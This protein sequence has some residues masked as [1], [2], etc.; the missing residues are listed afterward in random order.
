MLGTFRFW[1]YRTLVSLFTLIAFREQKV[2]PLEAPPEGKVDFAPYSDVHP[3]I[4]IKGLYMPTSFLPADKPD[5]RLKRIKF[6]TKLLTLVKGLAPATTP[7]VPTNEADFIAAVYPRAFRWAWP[8]APTVP[9]AIAATDDLVAELAVRGPYASF[10]RK[11]DDDRY[12]FGADWIGS[13]EVEPGLV[14]PGGTATLVATGGRLTTESIESAGSARGQTALLAA[15]NEDL[16]TFRHNVDVHL[17]IL[18]SF[19]LACTNHLGARHPVRRLLHHCFNTVMIGNFELSSAQLRGPRS[20]LPTIFSHR[21]EVLVRMVEDHLRDFDFWDY[22]P[23]TQFSRRGTTTTPFEYPYRDNVMDFWTE[24]SAYVENYLDIY[25]ENDDD[26]AGDPQVAS[27]AAELDRLLPN[28][29]AIP[30]GGPTFKWLVRLCAT[31]I[32]VSTVEH[33]ILNNVVWD[34]T[35]LGWITPTVVTATGEPMDQRRAFDLIAILI[36][37]W[38]PYN[39]LLTSDVPKLAL[40]D[41][42]AAVMQAWI[43]R[44]DRLQVKMTSDHRWDAS[45]SYPSALNVSISN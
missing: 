42:A 34:Y 32:H 14:N 43:D 3:D 36:G 8:D 20:F 35:T 6:Q 19:A 17:T 25:Y 30:L 45:L 38:K 41:R 18:T 21:A 10:L 27:W 22:E 37:T 24:T 13:Y 2:T 1:V 29:V 15:L 44:L 5:S 7:P 23:P 40:D 33:D 12:E 16:T 4:P 26:V 39:M 9:A 11:S 28:G 31:L